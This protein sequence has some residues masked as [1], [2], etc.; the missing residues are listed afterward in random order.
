MELYTY[1]AKI[2]S[3]YD[4]DTCT[5][6]VDLGFYMVQRKVKVRLYGI[7]TA[8]LR[9][10]TEETKQAAVQARDYLRKCVLNQEV[11]LKSCGKGK[12]GRWLCEIFV[13]DPQTG[14]KTNVNQKLIELGLAVPYMV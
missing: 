3:V 12:Y 11:L 14:E 13:V 7:N 6:D 9:G 10:G 4:G 8:E 1:K 2:T 5:A